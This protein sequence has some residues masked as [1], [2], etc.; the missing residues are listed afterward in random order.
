MTNVSPN[1]KEF[2]IL[3]QIPQGSLPLE[4]T[5]Y[6]KSI[7]Q[8]LSPYTTN[9]M[10]FYFYFPQEGKFLHFPSNA[11]HKQKITARAAVNTLNVVKTLSVSKKETFRDILQT[12]SKD[13][14]LEFLRK[15]NLLKSEKGFSF[16]DLLWMM[17]DKAFFKKVLEILRER[18]IFNSEIWSFAFYNKDDELAVKEYLARLNP[19]NIINNLGTFF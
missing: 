2:S 1:Q 16:N 4:M 12:G 8:V 11:S 14:I 15:Y 6:M 19:Y 18:Y 9:K 10:I 3:Y 7:P 17:K 5:K 13:D